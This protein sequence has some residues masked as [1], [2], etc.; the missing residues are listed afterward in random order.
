M[1]DKFFAPG[2]AWHT[3]AELNGA[4]AITDAD[5]NHVPYADL[6]KRASQHID[7]LLARKNNRRTKWLKKVR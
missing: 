4:A 2:S 5:G 7:A 6:M 3:A 1:T